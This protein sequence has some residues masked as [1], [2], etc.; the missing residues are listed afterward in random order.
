MA[1]RGS[2]D[3]NPFV[4]GPREETQAIPSRAEQAIKAIAALGDR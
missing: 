3:S 1:V 2:Y 4:K